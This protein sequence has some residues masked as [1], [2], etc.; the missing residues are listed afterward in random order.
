LCWSEIHVAPQDILGPKKRDGFFDAFRI[1]RLQV[2][3]NE[4]TVLP[5]DPEVETIDPETVKK[6]EKIR[7]S[8]GESHFPLS[9]PLGGWCGSSENPSGHEDLSGVRPSMVGRLKS[10]S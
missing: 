9:S 1:E 10:F 5:P 7:M 8:V 4:G 2:P 6:V 3:L